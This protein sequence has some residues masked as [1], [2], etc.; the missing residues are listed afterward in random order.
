MT[1]IPYCDR[2]WNPIGGCTH[3]S[4]GC[5]NCWAERLVATRFTGKSR[6]DGLTKNGRW[7]GDIKL[8]EDRLE[9]PLHWRKP[10]RI[11]VCSQADLFHPDVPFEFVDKMFDVIWEAPQH[12]YLI[13]TK[14]PKIMAAWLARKTKRLK[15]QQQRPIILAGISIC[16]QKEAD[17]KIP[18]L[19]QTPAA[20]RW[21]SIE[22][23]LGP[24]DL[25]WNIV[26]P[27]QRCSSRIRN[28]TPMRGLDWVVVGCES[29]P[30]RRP[31]KLEWILDIVQECKAA[32]VKCY[33]KQ[34]S[35]NGK[36]STTPAEW[37]EELRVQ[38]V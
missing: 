20:K 24:V 1:A 15:Q 11:F 7:T 36:A 27:S 6:Y 21:V 25:K 19:L 2:T 18:I 17:K 5:V 12:A 34:I 8:F 30:S 10:Q 31:C 9:Q 37:P 38:E 26:Y 22:P 28:E 32:G 14:R 13:L 4:P 33:V 23:M 35:I 16:N 29:G 3:C